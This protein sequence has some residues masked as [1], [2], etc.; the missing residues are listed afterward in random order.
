MRVRS[1]EFEGI[2]YELVSTDPEDS[3]FIIMKPTR[4]S[5]LPG[6]T[7]F[8]FMSH[9]T[10]QLGQFAT[11]HFPR[12]L[13]GQRV[14]GSPVWTSMAEQSLYG[15]ECAVCGERKEQ[16]ILSDCNHPICIECGTQWHLQQNSSNTTTPCPLCRRPWQH[17]DAIYSNVN[18]Q[19]IDPLC[20]NRLRC[21]WCGCIAQY[22]CKC[23]CFE[24]C[25]LKCKSSHGAAG[26]TQE[27]VDPWFLPN[28]QRLSDNA[29]LHWTGDRF[30]QVT[31]T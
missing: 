29:C 20:F 11:T 16:T 18:D 31:C 15:R 23:Q 12:V 3:S 25:S 22:R 5:P 2:G 17:F 27:C 24:Y 19:V 30:E 28:S 13:T 1:L 4:Q 7:R 9:D 10:M 8:H 6:N 26:H 21:C 14:E